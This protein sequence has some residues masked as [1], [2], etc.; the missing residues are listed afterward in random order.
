[1]FICIAYKHYKTAPNTCSVNV[2]CP[3]AGQSLGIGVPAQQH[4]TEDPASH[5]VKPTPVPAATRQDGRSATSQA[6]LMHTKSSS[7]QGPQASGA[8]SAATESAAAAGSAAPASALPPALDTAVLAAPASALP[9]TLGTAVL[10]APAELG[11]TQSTA[12]TS[13]PAQAPP[14][15]AALSTPAS[16][17]VDSSLPHAMTVPPQASHLIPA[18]AGQ[19]QFPLP[20]A[21]PLD[22]APLAPE[23]VPTVDLPVPHP[24]QQQ[25]SQGLP[26]A[27]QT[28]HVQAM[29]FHSAGTALH[30]LRQASLKGPRHSTVHVEDAAPQHRPSLH[31]ELNHTT[32]PTATKATDVE[33]TAAATATEATA[34]ATTATVGASNMPAHLDAAGDS[35]CAQQSPDSLSDGKADC[36]P[37]A[38]P[39]AHG[40]ATTHASTVPSAALSSERTGAGRAGSIGSEQPRHRHTSS[41]VATQTAND[42]AQAVSTAGLAAITAGYMSLAAEEGRSTAEKVPEQAP[43]ADGSSV[44]NPWMQRLLAALSLD[45]DEVGC[46]SVLSTVHSDA[47]PPFGLM[48]EAAQESRQLP[49]DLL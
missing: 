5:V 49:A 25:S 30:A 41:G 18:S 17:N 9:L 24:Q 38:V 34:T 14:H 27:Q 42:E 19:L 31:T 28:Q 29:H 7:S 45:T 1:M 15:H 46:A 2:L 47:E 3:P 40:F 43:A 11:V 16:N 12:D 13:A 23:A 6:T 33:A 10:A 44:V 32:A 37:P 35:G 22:T 8:S 4:S 21:A 26:A 20:L 39:A 36:R 48:N